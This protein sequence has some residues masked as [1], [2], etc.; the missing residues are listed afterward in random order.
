MRIVTGAGFHSW[1]GIE[2]EGDRLSERDGVAK[3]KALLERIAGEMK[4]GEHR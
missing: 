3:T 1:M 2:F 4:A